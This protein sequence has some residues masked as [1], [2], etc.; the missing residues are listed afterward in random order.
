MGRWR[1]RARVGGAEAKRDYLGGV[2]QTLNSY[3][4]V[5]Y[6]YSMFNIQEE[7]FR[8]TLSIRTFR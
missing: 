1:C 5:G 4:L 2:R 6:N 3:Y 7:Y 8:V